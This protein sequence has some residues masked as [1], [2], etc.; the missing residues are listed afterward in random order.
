MRK[1]LLFSFL[2]LVFF[3][4]QKE[5]KTEQEWTS[6]FDGKSLDGW[7]VRGGEGDFYVENGMIVGNS[8]LNVEN[9]FL[10]TE[11]EYDDF[12][13]KFDVKIDSGLNSG[14]QVRSHVW[15]HDTTTTY[16]SGSGER[17]ERTWKAGRVWGYQIE[18][19]PSDRAWSGGFY[20]EGNRGW[21]VTLADND[22]ARQAFKPGEWNS[23]KVKADGNHFQTW[24]NGVQ[25]VDT[26]DDMSDSGFLGLQLHSINDENLAGKKVYWKNI[27][28]KKL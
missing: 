8:Q 11:K 4:C 18:V 5:P 17:S 24:V 20:E 27:K 19:D 13:L 25:A 21:L 6:L 26:T 9:S 2:V 3:A 15:Q 23:F 14:M 12:I 1:I 16:L 7:T 10:C 28:L 22:S